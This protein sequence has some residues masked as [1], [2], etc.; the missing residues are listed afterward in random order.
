MK[1]YKIRIDYVMSREVEFEIDEKANPFERA[2][3]IS[4]EPVSLKCLTATKKFVHFLE[5]LELK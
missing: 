4:Q 5:G 3:E 2:E 1:K